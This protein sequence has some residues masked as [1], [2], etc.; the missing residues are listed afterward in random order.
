MMLNITN[1]YRNTNY[2][3]TPVR[4]AFISK[5]TNVGKDISNS[6]VYC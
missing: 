3:L 6:V 5:S 1:H 2:H 4:M